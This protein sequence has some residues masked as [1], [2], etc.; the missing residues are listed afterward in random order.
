MGLEPTK[1]SKKISCPCRRDKNEMEEGKN[2]KIQD[3]LYKAWYL[4]T[5]KGGFWKIVE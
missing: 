3:K 1:G 5:N 2:M 4:K